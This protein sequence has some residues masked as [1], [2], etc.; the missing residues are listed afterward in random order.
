MPENVS[1]HL[2]ADGSGNQLSISNISFNEPTSPIDDSKMNM[3]TKDSAGN[4]TMNA[5]SKIAQAS[6]QRKTTIGSGLPKP[7]AVGGKLDIAKVF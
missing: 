3:S 5:G 7:K 4:S 6:I 2:P 1:D